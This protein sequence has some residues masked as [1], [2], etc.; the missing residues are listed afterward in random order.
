MYNRT[1]LKTGITGSVIA[2]VCCATPILVILLAAVGLSAWAAWLDFVLIP[3]L[4]I[5]V[6][7]T[8]YALRR[9]RAEAACGEAE[10]G[11]NHK[12]ER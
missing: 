6:G 3:A 8:I 5:F 10:S 7:I 11:L 1:L 2:A 12:K 9:R 4:V